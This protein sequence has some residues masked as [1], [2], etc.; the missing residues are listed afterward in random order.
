LLGRSGELSWGATYAFSDAED[1]WIEERRGGKLRRIVDGHERWITPQARVEVIRRKKHPPLELTF[2]ETEHGTLDGPLSEDG[3]TLSTRWAGAGLGAA[4]L[5]GIVDAARARDVEQGMAA[6]GKL[7]SA[8]NWVLA[9]RQGNIGYQMSGT[10]P[11]RRPGASGLLPLPGWDA[12]NDWLGWVTPEELPRQ[13]NPAC[14]YIATANDD[15]NALGKV[16][17]INLPMGAWRAERIRALLAEG[18]DLDPHQFRQMHMDVVSPQARAF[19]D[20]LHPLLPDTPAGRLLK[21]WDC[22]YT[23]SSRAATLFETLYEGLLHEVFAPVWGADLHGHLARETATFVDFAAC[24]D[25]ILLGQSSA[26]FGDRTRDEI[27]RAVVAKHL[28]APVIPWG[29]K[30]RFVL[31]HVL[32]GDKLPGFAGFNR[33]PLSLPGGR[34]TIHQ[35]QLYRSGGRQTSFAPS[36]R[37]TADMADD[38]AHTSLPG[39]PSDRRFSPFYASGLED[40]AAGRTKQLLGFEV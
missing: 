2:Y 24:F 36:W 27:L 4:S 15:L 17:P 25:R 8:F 34:A 37:F 38:L 3:L 28:D 35:G 31:R 6:L 21:T 22:R 30:Q 20:L 1:S 10:V 39:G 13:L 7:E 16:G 9:D 18:R 26:W 12:A 29:E 19:V 33:G 23:L 40:W 32:L 14:G 5:R 11:R